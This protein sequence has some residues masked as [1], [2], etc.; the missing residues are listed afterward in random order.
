M[1]SPNKRFKI[2]QSPLYA[3]LTLIFILLCRV[4]LFFLPL[5]DSTEARYAEIARKMLETGNWITPMQDYGIPF[6][7][8]PPLSFWLSAFSM[9]LLGVNEF[10]ARLPSLFLSLGVLWLIFGVAKKHS[11]SPMAMAATLVLASSLGFFLDAGAVMTDPSL[12]FCTT[13]TLVSFW[14]AVVEK[15][16]VWRYW[17]FVGLGLGL[18]AKG[19]LVL[20]L[21]GIPIF[22][23]VL[24]HHQWR[25]LWQNLPWIKGVFLTLLIALPWYLLAEYRTPGFINYFIVGEHLGRFLQSEWQG[26]KYGNA[27]SEPLG[28]IWTIGSIGMLPWTPGIIIWLLCYHKKIPGLCKS[29]ANWVSYWFLCWLMPLLFFTFSK[30]IIWP[31]I[32]PSMPAFALLFAELHQSTGKSSL[33]RKLLIAIAAMSAPL[34]TVVILYYYAP[35]NALKSQKPVIALWRDQAPSSQSHLI[36]WTHMTRALFSAQF[37]SAGKAEV[38]DNPVQ[39]KQLLSNHLD[40]YIIT[41]STDLFLDLPKELLPQVTKIKTIQ[42]GEGTFVLYQA[43][44]Y[45]PID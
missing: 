13:L 31:Y 11:R 18:L 28:M 8:K 41:C 25:N 40:N 33:F 44:A 12:L 26:D 45:R 38:T 3:T 43:K 1:N 5:N 42:T 21:T 16:T 36:Y 10:A 35:Q 22:L 4:G 15:E 30:N 32:L 14:R 2:N 19:P 17:F 34:Y 27:H 29:N 23:W 39:L 20:V 6:W 9:K 24:F 7:A 37:Y